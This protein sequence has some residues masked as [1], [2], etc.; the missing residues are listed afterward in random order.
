LAVKVTENIC[1]SCYTGYSKTME[2]WGGNW[3]VW[4]GN[5]VVLFSLCRYCKV[6]IL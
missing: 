1:P 6:F 4:L 2:G 5:K 3:K